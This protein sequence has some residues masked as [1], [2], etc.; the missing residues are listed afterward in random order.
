MKGTN[1]EPTVGG[2]G[3]RGHFKN[4]QCKSAVARRPYS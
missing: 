1:T 2:V 4:M 3:N